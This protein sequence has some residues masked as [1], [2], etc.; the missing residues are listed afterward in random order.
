MAFETGVDVQVG[1]TGPKLALKSTK[2]R[3]KLDFRSFEF[4]PNAC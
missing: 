4:D 3:S 1:F 2:I